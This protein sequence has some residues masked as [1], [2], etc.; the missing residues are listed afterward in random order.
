MR[1]ALYVDHI[2][3]KEETTG[4]TGPLSDISEE[5]TPYRRL[6]AIFKTLSPLATSSST[7]KVYE[8]S[9]QSSFAELAAVHSESYT[10][11]LAGAWEL[12]NTAQ[13]ED[14][15]C[16]ETQ[17]LHVSMHMSQLPTCYKEGKFAYKAAGFYT[18][19]ETTRIFART[20]RDAAISAKT[21]ICAA[22]LLLS[23]K[24]NR[25][26]A[27]TTHP[28][29]HAKKSNYEGYC[30]F[31]NAALAI[32][33]LLKSGMTKIAVLDLDV[34]AGNGTKEIFYK[35]NQVFTISLHSDPTVEY[36]HRE[37]FS[38]EIGEGEGKGF[39]VNLIFGPKVS[40][41][42]YF[43]L[44]EQ[45]LT[46]IEE[47]KPE[48]LVI[49]FGGD[50]YCEDPEVNSL[51]GAKLD[52]DDYLTLGQMISKRFSNPILIT[53]EGGYSIENIGQIVANF[54]LGLGFPKTK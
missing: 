34:H 39:N 32:F 27:L 18:M 21:A 1:C 17:S 38:D 44:V 6:K 3:T 13:D 52:F 10:R 26:Y 50:T 24:L 23:E 25:V 54:L 11:W 41:K 40:A 15:F 2:E 46:Q 16:S 7:C 45:A 9:D 51:A 30:F 33:Q 49:P 48:I 22:D 35:S 19:D 53:Q 43:R 8:N 37:G 14:W 36:P 12:A 42:E 31:N 20:F 5:R 4:P 29:H 47:F 28:G